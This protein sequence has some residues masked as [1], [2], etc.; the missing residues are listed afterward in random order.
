MVLHYS[1]GADYDCPVR[2]FFEALVTI[3]ATAKHYPN[4]PKS[5]TPKTVVRI[6]GDGYLTFGLPLTVT[7]QRIA[8]IPLIQGRLSRRYSGM[9]SGCGGRGRED[10]ARSR[11]ARASSLPILRSAREVLTGLGQAKAGNTRSDQGPRKHGLSC[12][13]GDVSPLGESRGGTPTGK[14]AP[15]KLS[16]AN[17]RGQRD[18]CAAAAGAEVVTQRLSAFRFPFAFGGEG[19]KRK[20]PRRSSGAEILKRLI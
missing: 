16:P 17:G 12:A 13:R 10:T 4:S 20:G 14:H 7:Y 18:S 15:S 11:L 5:C 6:N 9:R 2:A 19:K 8:R 1:A 3:C